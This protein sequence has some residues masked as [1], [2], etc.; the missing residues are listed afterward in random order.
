MWIK[1][2]TPVTISAIVVESGSTRRRRGTWNAPDEDSP[3]DADSWELGRSYGQFPRTL[4]AHDE[5][6]LNAAHAEVDCQLA[7]M[8]EH[9]RHMEGD[10]LSLRHLSAPG[11]ARHPRRLLVAEA[12]HARQKAL[13]RLSKRR[14]HARFFDVLIRRVGQHTLP[15]GAAHVL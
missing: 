12:V 1:N 9:V 10:D 2:P 15:L 5:E 8:V 13:S 4:L 6:R 7:V 11:R 3:G 14:Q